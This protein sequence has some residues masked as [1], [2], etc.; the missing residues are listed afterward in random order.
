[1]E[2]TA[3]HPQQDQALYLEVGSPEERAEKMKGEKMNEGRALGVPVP[4]VLMLVSQKV[5]LL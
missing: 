3:R 4:S 5:L 2:R 1:M